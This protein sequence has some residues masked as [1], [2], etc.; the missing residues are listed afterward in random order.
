MAVGL[1]QGWECQV[2]TLVPA[3]STSTEAV[4]ACHSFDPWLVVVGNRYGEGKIRWGLP[5]SS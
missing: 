3:A 1:Q 2:V 5:P 4:S